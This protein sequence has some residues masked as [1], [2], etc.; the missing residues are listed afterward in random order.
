[1]G[2]YPY[3]AGTLHTG[4]AQ[5]VLT[6]LGSLGGDRSVAYSINNVGQIT[7]TS[8]TADKW[9][10]PF[11]YENGTMTNLGTFVGNYGNGWGADIN[12]NGQI[13]G[14]ASTGAVYAAFLRE[15][16]GLL[17]LGTL[18][19][20]GSRAT[21][22]N[23]NGT[24]VGETSTASGDRV[25]FISKDG[26][27]MT[28]INTP[29]NNWSVANGI[30][31]IGE[32]VGYLYNSQGT[33]NGEGTDGERAVMWNELG[34]MINLQDLGGKASGASK[35]NDNGIAVGWAYTPDDLR[36][37]VI[38]NNNQITALPNL[39]RYASA[40]SINNKDQVVGQ[41]Y[42]DGS[43]VHEGFIAED[44]ETANLNALIK[45]PFN[46]LLKT[47]FDINDKGQ[48]VG[49]A[50]NIS[51]G[52]DHAVLLTPI[53]G[54]SQRNPVLPNNISQGNFNFSNVNSGLWYDPPTTSGFNFQ[55]N[56]SSG[57]T[58]GGGVSGDG[59]VA[60]PSTIATVPNTSQDSLFTKILS[61]PSGFNEPFTVSVGN[62]I[63]GQFKAGDSVIFS[64][65]KNLLGN[66][67]LDGI[68]VNQFKVT[69]ISV[70]T[71]DPTVF[72]I[73]L[74][75]NTSTANFSMN[76]ILSD[77]NTS[78]AVPEPSLIL[79]ILSSGVYFARTAYKRKRKIH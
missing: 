34:N 41:Y 65:Y 77:N 46:F 59:C 25:A 78:E 47:A 48:I 4:F 51:S 53:C 29:N 68:G 63:L 54:S 38:W 67:L 17:N 56:N 60:Y 20:N 72:P 21:S 52:Q 22:I 79:G 71:N 6:D 14:A 8:L 70:T 49:N 61:L 69:G 15:N 58:S 36:R 64:D 3:N 57:A 42:R 10:S 9:E 27:Q 24:V 40:M 13:A 35:I 31:N 76:Q 28:A 2:N 18:G 75:F 55:M 39:G 66:L 37:A 50:L 12:N 16:A 45:N 44:G 32:I 62:I 5:Y 73:K 11:L 74:A 30:N 7:G 19:T 23:D 33:L 43:I 1:M 26:Q